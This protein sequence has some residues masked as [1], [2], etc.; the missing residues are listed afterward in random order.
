MEF[1][2]EA[3][4]F[5]VQTLAC[6]CDQQPKRCN[7]E[8]NLTHYQSGG[9]NCNVPRGTLM[10]AWHARV[11][12]ACRGAASADVPS[13]QGGSDSAAMPGRSESLTDPGTSSKPHA[14]ATLVPDD[15]DQ[16]SGADDPT[17]NDQFA[18]PR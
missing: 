2:R 5:R 10:L 12:V 4:Q 1:F 6:I 18:G 3:D 11:A 14:R 9:T 7:S 15:N 16:A 13:Q 8:L 17:E